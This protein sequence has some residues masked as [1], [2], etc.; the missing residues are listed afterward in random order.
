MM[1]R[2][3]VQ[4]AMDEIKQTDLIDFVKIIEA[5]YLNNSRPLRDRLKVSRKNTVGR[6]EYRFNTV[7]GTE[8]FS[9]C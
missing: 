3:I 6:P 9:A 1:V 8:L 5:I 7:I 4:D 2:M